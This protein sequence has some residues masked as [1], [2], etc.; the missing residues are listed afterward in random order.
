MVKEYG[1]DEFLHIHVIP[2]E[3]LELLNNVTSPLLRGKGKTICEVWK[4]LLKKPDNYKIIS[5]EHFLEPLMRER[6][7]KSLLQY[8]EKRYW[9]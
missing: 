1:C 7:T 2:D 9:Q 8:L 6:D 4:S 3:N 5:P